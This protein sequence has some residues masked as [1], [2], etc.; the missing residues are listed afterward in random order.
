MTEQNRAQ[1]TYKWKVAV[2]REI[3]TIR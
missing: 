1:F 2:S 3:L